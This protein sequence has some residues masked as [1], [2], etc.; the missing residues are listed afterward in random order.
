MAHGD[1]EPVI[2]IGTIIVFTWLLT[3]VFGYALNL[4]PA[5]ALV[6]FFMQ[7]RPFIVY[8]LILLVPAFFFKYLNGSLV[9]FVAGVILF[10]S[11]KSGI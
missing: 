8:A 3:T 6:E 5:E 11:L 9:M 1:I 10:L 4:G 7:P 2:T